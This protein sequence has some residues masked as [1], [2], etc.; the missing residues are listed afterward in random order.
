MATFVSRR[1]RLSHDAAAHPD[2]CA[3]APRDDSL[4]P[5]RADGGVGAG[6]VV[7][8]CLHLLAVGVRLLVD[9]LEVT[10][11]LGDELLAGHRTRAAPEVAGGQHITNDG[12]VLLLQRGSLLADGRAMGVDI[13]ELV[14]N[15]HLSILLIFESLRWQ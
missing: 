7:A 15:R 6:H 14:V 2:R 12:L 5:A 11:Q 9:H 1:A 13:S 3:A 10:T 4:S 8:R